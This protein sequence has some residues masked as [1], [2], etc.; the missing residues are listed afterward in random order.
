MSI[1]DLESYFNN[2]KLPGSIQLG[3]GVKINNIATFVESHIRVVKNYPTN[4]AYQ[5]FYIRLMALKELLDKN[6]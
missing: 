4:N 1:N 5:G 6:E 3:P 2:K